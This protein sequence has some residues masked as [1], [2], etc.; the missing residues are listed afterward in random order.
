MHLYE[1]PRGQNRGIL[2]AVA[3]FAM[4]AVLFLIALV[5]T[6]RRSDAREAEMVSAALQRAIVTCYAVEGKYP[7]SLSYIYDNY[8]VRVDESR[9]TVF[10]DVIAANMKPSVRVMR[11]GG[12]S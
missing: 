6:A 10:Y 5:S 2:F 4:L 8:G 7:P 1:R 9:Y 11:T 3:V 12:G